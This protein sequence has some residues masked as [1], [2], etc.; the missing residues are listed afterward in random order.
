M[1]NA[2]KANDKSILKT[3]E[4][5]GL[6][7]SGKSTL[8]NNLLK[9]RNRKDP[10]FLMID[11]AIYTAKLQAFPNRLTLFF[12]SKL[13]KFIV[14]RIIKILDTNMNSTMN[15]EEK[16][17][18]DGKYDEFISNSFTAAA[19]VQSTLSYRL[20]TVEWF[21]HQIRSIALVESLQVPNLPILIDEGLLNRSYGFGISSS[22]HPYFITMPIPRAILYLEIDPIVAMERIRSRMSTR[23]IN[24][25]SNLTHSEIQHDLYQNKK[26]LEEGL[27]VIEQ[28]GGIVH[29]ID[30]SQ[31]PGNTALNVLDLLSTDC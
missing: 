5:C 15:A 16:L 2:L 20:K 11:E 19:T 26:T 6:P 27:E 12:S 25:H 3:I 14:S 7:G 4:I 24:R 30:A 22:D 1:G 8:I 28:R 29:R 21:I 17:I 23:I 31:L 9:L 18:F 13:P 10:E